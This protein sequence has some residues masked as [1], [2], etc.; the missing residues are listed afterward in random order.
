V[1]K[2]IVSIDRTYVQFDLIEIE[3]ADENDAENLGYALAYAYPGTALGD[4]P[5]VEIDRLQLE[6]AIVRCE[7]EVQP[8]KEEAHA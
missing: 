5:P 2:Y 6:D 8:E 7:D 3:A 4:L 1:P